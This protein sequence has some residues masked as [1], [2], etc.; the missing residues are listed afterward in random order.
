M[1]RTVANLIKYRPPLR[2]IGY[3]DVDQNIYSQE[4]PWIVISWAGSKGHFCVRGKCP[5][6]S[7][8]FS[9]PT[10]LPLYPSPGPPLAQPLLPLPH[11]QPPTS[12]HT[13]PQFSA[14]SWSTQSSREWAALRHWHRSLCCASISRSPG[15]GLLDM[16][17]GTF[18]TS[19]CGHRPMVG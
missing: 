11:S 13:P 18:A 8:Y 2:R 7:L 12:H 5:S 6:W 9:G 10:S 16:P 15:V 17:Y 3:Q 14:G 1:T 4:L 19:Y